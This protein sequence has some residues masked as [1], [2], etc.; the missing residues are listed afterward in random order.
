M[1]RIGG[2]PEGSGEQEEKALEHGINSASA[3][4][5]GGATSLVKT[6]GNA[7]VGDRPDYIESGKSSTCRGST[8]SD[9]SEE[10][11]CS[12]LSC[13]INK[14]HK[15]NDIRWDALVGVSSSAGV[16]PGPSFGGVS[17]GAS[18]KGYSS[19]L[20]V[21]SVVGLRRN[22]HVGISPIA[23]FH[24]EPGLG[25]ISVGA[26]IKGDPPPLE[27]PTLVDQKQDGPLGMR[28]GIPNAVDEKPTSV[29]NGDG[30]TVADGES[31]IL[32]IDGLPTDCTRREVGRIF[33]FPMHAFVMNIFLNKIPRRF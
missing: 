14:P 21:P 11:T 16:H 32:F 3:K 27:D 10:N 12:N 22:A 33:F 7:K 8:S 6:S 28:P 23:G 5:N 1:N 24:P 13:S 26:S 19:S 20:K 25:A 29:R 30:P 2:L 15:A 4:S 18:I 17:A 9:L 31:N